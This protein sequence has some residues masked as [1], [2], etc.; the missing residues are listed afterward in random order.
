VTVSEL[1]DPSA[2]RPLIGL[3]AG[4]R[5]GRTNPP[6]VAVNRSYLDGLHAAGADVVLLA[7]SRHG[8]PPAL[9]DAL[10]GVLVPGGVDVGPTHYGE[11]PREGLGEVDDGLDD[12]E[13]PLVRA[14]VERRL[15]LFG[16]CRGQQVV[17]V[18]LGGTLYQ[19][20]AR[21]GATDLP[22]ATPREL[23]RDHLA[24]GIEVTPSSHLHRALGG[25][26]LAVNSFHHQAVRRV[27][28]GL[29]VTAVSPGDGVIEGLESADGLVITVQCH[30]E[31]L[32][33][34]A[35]A[36]HLFASFVATARERSPRPVRS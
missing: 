10:D 36:R 20:L 25:T 12:L 19:D 26:R 18:A 31:E 21:D 32:T 5:H 29:E 17:N 30:P 1:T 13:L 2:P 35:W 22:H 16:I 11:R 8:V 33:A 28:P 24:H 6:R 3:T 23:G 34:H 7:P 4:N 14:A 9:L 27:A 15:P